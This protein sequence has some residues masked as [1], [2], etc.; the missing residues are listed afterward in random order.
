MEQVERSEKAR[1]NTDESV[2]ELQI[3]LENVN[4][5]TSNK[6]KVSQKLSHELEEVKQKL[7]VA[8]EELKRVRSDA[9][10]FHKTLCSLKEG[11]QSSLFLTDSALQKS[12]A[13]RSR[14]S[15]PVCSESDSY[16]SINDNDVKF[17]LKRSKDSEKESNGIDDS[18]GDILSGNQNSVKHIQEME[19]D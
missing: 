8:E 15:S 2:K 10:R 1:L 3:Q 11:L 4:E 7:R 5:A 16:N 18:S 17:E 13:T 6:E 9:D 12:R 19:I 14:K